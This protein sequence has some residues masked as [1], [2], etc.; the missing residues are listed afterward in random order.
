MNYI[1]KKNVFLVSNK[2][3]R[4]KILYINLRVVTSKIKLKLKTQIV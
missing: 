3:G 2:T 1:I 4:K